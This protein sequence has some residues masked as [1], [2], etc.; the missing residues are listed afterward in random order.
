MSA[1]AAPRAIS[2]SPSGWKSTSPPIGAITTGH[3]SG[4]PSSEVERSIWRTS[5]RMSWR[6][7]RRRSERRFRRSVVSVSVPPAP[8]LYEV[9]GKRA[10][11]ARCISGSVDEGLGHGGYDN[12]CRT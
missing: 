5:T 10:R 12:A 6:M 8:K 7:A 1:L 9:R 11:A 2:Q 3:E 4:T